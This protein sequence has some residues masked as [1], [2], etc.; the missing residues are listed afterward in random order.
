LSIVLIESDRF[1][2]HHWYKRKRYKW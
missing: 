1:I 2:D